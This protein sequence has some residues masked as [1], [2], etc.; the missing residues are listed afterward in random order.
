MYIASV[1]SIFHSCLPFQ[2]SLSSLAEDKAVELQ[3]RALGLLTDTQPNFVDTLINI[4]QLKT[5]DPSIQ[6][7]QIYK[8]QALNCYKEVSEWFDFWYNKNSISPY[9]LKRQLN[10]GTCLVLSVFFPQAVTL[11][12]KLGLQTELNTEEVRLRFFS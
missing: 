10:F 8:L 6:C 9:N 2:V 12:I 7:M 3:R 1:F 5:L 4:Y 11:S